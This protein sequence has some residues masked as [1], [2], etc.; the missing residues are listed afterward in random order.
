MIKLNK[1]L[2]CGKLLISEPFLGD[3]FF[4][5]AVVLLS[6]HNKD[7]TVGFILNKPTDIFINDIIEDFPDFDV[8]VYFG[9]PVQKD[10]LHYI[11]KL[12]DKVQGCKEI[13]KGIYWGGD[14]EILKLLIDTKQ[15]SP[16][17]I[18]FFIGYSGWNPNQLKKEIAEKSW[19]LTPATDNFTFFDEPKKLWSDVMK[20]LGKEYSILA[21]FPEDPSMN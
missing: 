19:L 10:T 21:N 8:P 15:V 1:I 13:K 16:S 2:E 4:K 3:P 6:E 9:G 14:F 11:H 5:R 20:S 18:R 17:D 12:G 7:G